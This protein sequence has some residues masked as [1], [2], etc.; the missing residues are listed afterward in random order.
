M[1]LL[2][3]IIPPV[4]GS[5]H[6]FPEFKQGIPYNPPY[7]PLNLENMAPLKAGDSFPEGISFSYVPSTPEDNDILKCSI[8]IKYDA[9][10]GEY[11][12]RASPG[13]ETTGPL[14]SPQYRQH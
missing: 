11:K 3:L 5:S 13:Y 8:P 2:N 10:T 14:T 9:S 1:R 4:Q 12:R 6:P 7:T